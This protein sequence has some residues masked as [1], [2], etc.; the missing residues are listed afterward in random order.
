MTDESTKIIP[1]HGALGNRASLM[2]YRKVMVSVRDRVSTL[3]AKKRTLQQVISAKPLADY[4]D[5]WGKGFMKPE[6]F[7]TIVYSSL[8]KSAAPRTSSEHHGK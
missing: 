3:I 7:L 2:E 1:G 4:D 8:A 5:T 6:Q